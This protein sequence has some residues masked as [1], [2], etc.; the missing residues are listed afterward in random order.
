[1]GLTKENYTIEEVHISRIKAGDTIMHNDIMH[2]VCPKNI[3]QDSFW[4]T[5]IFGDSYHSGYKKVK[6]ITFKSFK[7]V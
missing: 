3:K 7:K 5:S 2:T 1:M 6:R 4:G